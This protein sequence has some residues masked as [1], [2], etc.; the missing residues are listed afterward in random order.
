MYQRLRAFD[1]QYI[2]FPTFVAAANEIE[3]NLK[4]FRET[5][6]ARHMLVTGEP[7][8]GKTSLCRWLRHQHPVRELPER[9]LVEVLITT[10]PP[11]AT[12]IGIT[13]AMLDALG[14][15]YPDSGTVASKT[16]RIVKLSRACGVELTLF[17]EAQ[18]LQD[19]G[20]S[21]THYMV[22]DWFKDLND[23]LNVPS[24]LLGLPRL[25]YLLQS[26]D[27]LRRRFSSRCNLALGRSETLSIETECLQL[28]R[29]LVSLIELPVSCHP[30]TPQEM[31][32]RLYYCS[33]GRIAYIKKLLFAA[34]RHALELDMDNI[35]APLLERTFT[36]EI[37]WEGVGKLNPFHP[38]F[39]FRRLDRGGEPFQAAN[40]VQARRRA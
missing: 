7:G 24:V 34:L 37:W 5:G 11:S 25:G 36:E 22:G 33:D 13:A 8:T 20:G 19:R 29:S 28:F 23:V 31:G 12:V 21:S 40:P 38:D 18:H 27:Q 32:T 10:V 3:S 1:E 16:A 14:D 26:N 4:L 35:D 30:Y 17:D 2:P 15:P 39:E 9:N 6:I